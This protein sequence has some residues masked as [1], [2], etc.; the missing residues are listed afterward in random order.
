MDSD[1]AG[2]PPSDMTKAQLVVAL[3]RRPDALSREAAD[4]LDGSMAHLPPEW[5][6]SAPDDRLER[7]S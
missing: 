7:T 3:R 1:D 5:K 4:R 2:T 6:G